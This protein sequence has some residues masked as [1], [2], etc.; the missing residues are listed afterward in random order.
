MTAYGARRPRSGREGSLFSKRTRIA[1]PM[2]KTSFSDPE[3]DLPLPAQPSG[4]EH[5]GAQFFFWPRMAER[6]KAM[7]HSEYDPGAKERRPWTAGRKLGGKRALDLSAEELSACDG[8]SRAAP[9]PAIP[10][11]SVCFQQ[12]PLRRQ[13]APATVG[14]QRP[15]GSSHGPT[16]RGSLLFIE[17]SWTADERTATTIESQEAVR[18]FRNAD[19]DALPDVAGFLVI[20]PEPQRALSAK[21]KPI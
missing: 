17:R 7:G 21:I 9:V 12:R 2:S 19:P 14:G 20:A 3:P 6:R 10:P 13:A 15:L 8:V 16:S 1:K 11:A 4:V 5:D 18:V